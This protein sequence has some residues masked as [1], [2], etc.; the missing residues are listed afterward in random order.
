[1]RYF[2]RL[3]LIVHLFLIVLTRLTAQNNAIHIQQTGNVGI[4]TAT[5]EEKLQVD[6]N[7]K[8][9]GGIMDQTG[10]IMPAGA[11]LPFSGSVPPPGWVFCNGNAYSK[12][13]DQK[14][15]FAVIGTMYGSDGDK[16]R[17]P[18]LRGTFIMGAMPGDSNDSLSRRG[19]ADLHNHTVSLQSKTA[20]TANSVNHSHKFPS[21]WYNRSLADGK[22]NGIDIHSGNIQ[23]HTTQDAGSHS[24]QVTVVFPDT[25]SGNSTGKNRPQW[26][27]LNYIIKY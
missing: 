16:F 20:G 13:G 23:T 26:A 9:N 21:N 3:L 8:V 19:S 6:G 17:V 4:G 18:D 14:A 22:Y 25:L 11:I 7:I 27:A 1:M 10:L 12:T 24:H 5:P 2:V 15:L